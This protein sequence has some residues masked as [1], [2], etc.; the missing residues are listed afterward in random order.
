MNARPEPTSVPEE[1]TTARSAD[2]ILKAAGE[3]AKTHGVAGTTIAAVCRRSGL[4]VSSVYWHFEDKDG[5]FA[6][7]VRHSFADWLVTVPRWE[8]E[9]GTTLGEGVRNVLGVSYQTLGMVPDFMRVGMQ[10]LLE[11]ND[12]YA[13]TR[14][15]FLDCRLQVKRMISAWARRVE[16]SAPADQ[17]DDIATLVVAFA[18][19]SAVG[20]QIYPDW[21]PEEY[22]DLLSGVL[23][24]LPPTGRATS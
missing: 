6:E 3:L 4:P 12:T 1:E 9:E 18:D 14:R 13:K 16:Q 5:L 23:A 21:E 15:A 10:V 22:V 8:A 7:V 2:R 24:C 20:S 19:G 11:K 17:A